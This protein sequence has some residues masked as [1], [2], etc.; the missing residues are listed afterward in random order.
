MPWHR[1]L[2]LVFRNNAIK[3]RKWQSCCGHLGEPGC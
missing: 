3:L 2:F 1:K